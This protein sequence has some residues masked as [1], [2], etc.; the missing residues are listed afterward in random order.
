MRGRM[1]LEQ[2]K[3]IAFGGMIALCFATPALGWSEESHMT[4]A[5]IAYDDLAR[6]GPEILAA[7]NDILK[8]HPQYQQLEAYLG[9]LKGAERDRARLEWLARWPDDIRGSVYDRPKW[10]YELRVVSG[11]TS[12]W[13]FR[14]GDAVH[15][16]DINYHILADTRAKPADR[17]IAMG[18]LIHLVGDIQQPLHAGHLMNASFLTTD[19]AGTY[20][21]VK[22]PRDAQATN[23][24]QFWDR[25]LDKPGPAD[26][27]ARAWSMPLQKLWPRTRLPELSN[28]STA[29]MQFTYSLYESLA[30]A[31]TAAYRG[32]FLQASTGAETAPTVTERESQFV[33]EIA[34][35]RVATGGYRIADMLRLALSSSDVKP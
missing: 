30:L 31:R 25:A 3:W 28:G 33:D 34:K 24:H 19:H 5:A 35:R 16:F 22:R 21:F 4:T 9:D 29:Q 15:G 2:R 6:T 26:A 1:T 14:N 12:L 23:L 18:W 20:G 17:A 27:T 13:P 32:R 10:H 7:A 11:W 8:A